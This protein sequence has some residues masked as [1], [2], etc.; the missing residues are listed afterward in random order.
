LDSREAQRASLA[1]AAKLKGDVYVRLMDRLPDYADPASGP[2]QNVWV[3]T[4][5]NEKFSLSLETL[6][7]SLVGMPNIDGVLCYDLGLSEDTRRRIQSLGVTVILSS[8][9]LPLITADYIATYQFKIDGLAFAPA[10]LRDR[11]SPNSAFLWLDSGILVNGGVDR[12]RAIIDRQDHFIC[13]L[14]TRSLLYVRAFNHLP[15]WSESCGHF[16]FSPKDLCGSMLWAGIHGYRHGSPYQAQIVLE[17]L[18]YSLTQPQ[19]VAGPKFFEANLQRSIEASS[20]FRDAVSYAKANDLEIAT[21]HWW[22]SRHD[23]FLFTCLFYLAGRQPLSSAG[24]IEDVTVANQSAITAQE[25]GI[26]KPSA[27][28]SPDMLKYPETEFVIHRGTL[29]IRSSERQP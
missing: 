24:L 27:E 5:A 25:D 11:T 9:F 29:S 26:V 17:A 19:I 7:S 18:R 22:G 15:P 12:F 1:G 3:L 4:A 20:I 21:A 2:V 13:D 14:T 28:F 10:I 23:Q 16:P 8:D 6:I